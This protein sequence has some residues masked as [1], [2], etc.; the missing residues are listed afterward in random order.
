MY[1]SPPRGQSDLQSPYS[2]RLGPM[3]KIRFSGVR[4]ISPLSRWGRPAGRS[5]PGGFPGAKTR[6]GIA[7]KGRDQD[8]NE[9]FVEGNVARLIL[10]TPA[11]Q[12]KAAG[13]RP[14]V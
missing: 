9:R 14:G 6:V 4:K 10:R 7:R 3:G 5:N 1:G 2:L 13:K 12:R 8:R 11:S